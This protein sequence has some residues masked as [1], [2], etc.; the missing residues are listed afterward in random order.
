MALQ[1]HAKWFQHDSDAYLWAEK[2]ILLA[3]AAIRGNL[4]RPVRSSSALREACCPQLLWRGSFG[5]CRMT[6]GVNEE[7]SRQG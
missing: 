2:L 1:L 5:K 4:N 3:L 6:R 7:Q